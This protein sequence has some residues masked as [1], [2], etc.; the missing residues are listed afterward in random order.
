MKAM[1][2]KSADLWEAQSW[3]VGKPLLCPR[4][5]SSISLGKMDVVGKVLSATNKLQLY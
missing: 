5:A 3:E 2:D 4:H 1:K